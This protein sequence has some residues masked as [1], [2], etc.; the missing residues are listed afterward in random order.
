MMIYAKA[1]TIKAAMLAQATQDVRYYLNGLH[2]IKNQV[3]ATDGHRALRITED[4]INAPE[5]G[6]ILKLS[7]V[8]TMRGIETAV[9]DTDAGIVY[10]CSQVADKEKDFDDLGEGWYKTLRLAVGTVDV[11]DGRFPDFNR[12]FVTP[13]EGRAGVTEIGFNVEYFA[14]VTRI[15]KALKMKSSIVKIT[16]QSVTD[17]A[18]I[19]I[20]STNGVAEYAVMPARV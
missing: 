15:C 20:N 9:I 16:L 8:P 12:V 2:F 3:Q 18:F 6:I 14:T 4:L 5:D 17:A 10:W 7:A 13:K 11:V 1:A 19:S